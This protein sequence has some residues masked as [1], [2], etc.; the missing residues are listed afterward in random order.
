MQ[1]FKLWAKFSKTVGFK[2]QERASVRASLAFRVLA[3]Q[4]W[5]RGRRN[6]SSSDCLRLRPLNQIRYGIV[7]DSHGGSA[8]VSRRS[9]RRARALAAARGTAT[10]ALK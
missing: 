6:L 7:P 1:W 9:R 2:R 8:R 4:L 5:L 3:G 10:M